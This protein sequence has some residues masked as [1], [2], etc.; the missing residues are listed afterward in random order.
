MNEKKNFRNV[1][2]TGF[3]GAGKTAVGRLLAKRLGLKFLDLDEIIERETGAEIK[4]IFRQNGEGHFRDIEASVIKKLTS[5]AYGTGIIVATGG[6][7]VIRQSNRE[8][9]KGWGIVVCLRASVD[10]ILKRA[11]SGDERPLLTGGDR[12]KKVEGLLK[13]REEAYRDCD[14]ALDTTDLSVRDVAEKI[15]LFLDNAAQLIE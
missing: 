11:G 12:K 14:L 4:D 2:L 10:E 3:M 1:A 6:G 7:A 8:D 5:G 9:L 13:D 15:R